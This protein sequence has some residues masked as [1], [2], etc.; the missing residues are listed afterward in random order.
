MKKYWGLFILAVALIV[1]CGGDDGSITTPASQTT[2]PTTAAIVAP[3]VGDDGPGAVEIRV[4]DQPDDAVSSILITLENIQVHVSGGQEMSGWTTI[5]EEP[6]PFEL[7]ELMGIEELLG[8]AELEP[9]KYQQIRFDVVEAII[10]V[11]G[12]KRE[13]PVPSGKIR[14]VGGFEIKSGATTIVTL[15]FD[16]EKS[17]VFRP[18]QGPALV[19]VIKMLVRD[20]GQSLAEA[21]V[22]ADNESEDQGA[23]AQ[24]PATGPSSSGS[25][26]PILVVTPTN[27][28]LQ[29][30]SFWTAMGAGYF[31]DEG[32]TI[33]TVFPPV[34]DRAGQFMLMGFADVAL[35]PPPMYLPMIEAKE[36]IRVFANLIEDD[37]INLIVREEFAEANNLSEDLPLADKL[38]AIRGFKVG[39]APG[40]PV[41]LRVLFDTVG[42]D[43]DTDIEM[44]ILHGADQNPA[45]GDGS[46]D[47][48]Y[49]HTPYLETALN[50]QGAVIL[51]NQSAG[52]VPG[53][54]GRQSHSLVATRSFISEYR[55]RLVALTRAIH[56]AQQ[57]IHED[58]DAV[59][60]ALL[61]SGVP[62]LERSLLETIVHIYAP[63][64]PDS[65][66]VSI[67]GL[68]RAVE[69]FPAHR[70]P[71]DLTGIDFADYAALG[72]AEDA[73]LP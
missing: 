32:L 45:F 21:E 31:E 11:R 48:L 62:G 26:P 51:V 66:L 2:A 9:G 16:A 64:I 33:Q 52:E 42:M 53:L 13:S 65:P 44:V 19:P 15:D 12:A 7:M 37:P 1:A 71:P 68:E 70:P 22:V 23:S 58:E 38:E 29:F 39:V 5:V 47:A 56:R 34:P 40:P 6:Q 60:E 46:I 54:N 17:V 18:G 49:A 8:G 28:N 55:D 72:I 50:E 4:T 27:N 67:A 25:G 10:T 24:Q 35:L 36:D 14:L 59:V 69:L 61:N 73:I 41:R 63:A 20:E 30:M 57:L 3:T 43:A